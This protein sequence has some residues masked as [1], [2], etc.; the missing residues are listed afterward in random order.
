M[1]HTI[2]RLLA[3][4]VASTFLLATAEAAPILFD[5]GNGDFSD[6]NATPDGLA[7]FVIPDGAALGPLTNTQGGVTMALTGITTNG[8]GTYDSNS[9]GFGIVSANETGGAA[10][11]SRA[12]A[13]PNRAPLGRS[14]RSRLASRYSGGGSTGDPCAPRLLRC[15]DGRG[16][17]GDH[18]PPHHGALGAA[19]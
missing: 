6:N 9:Q 7:N 11:Q 19:V 1:N 12:L 10:A 15:R 14:D 16:D 4:G 18:H 2:Q 3:L 13:R 8:P 17:R 5:F